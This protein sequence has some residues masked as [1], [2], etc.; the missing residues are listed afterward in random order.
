M[1]HKN[2]LTTWLE[3]YGHW[4][5][6]GEFLQYGGQS[7]EVSGEFWS[8][9]ELGNIE[10]RAASSCAH[11]YG[12]RKVSSESFTSG[13]TAFSGYPL[14]MKRRGDRFFTEGINNTLL[15]VYIQQPYDDKYPGVNAPFG[16]EFNRKNTWFSYLDLFISYLKRCDYLL[17]Q[18]TYVADV[19]YFIGEDTPKMTGVCDPAL[20]QGYSFDY[21][22][23]EVLLKANVK[24]GKIILPGGMSYR[25]LIL[26]KQETMRPELLKKI[27]KLIHAGAVVVGEPPK[28][29]PSLRHYPEAD[30]QVS[31]SARQ[32]W[33]KVDGKTLRFANVGKG[34]IINGMD[35]KEVFLLIGHRPDCLIEHNDSILFVHR[36]LKDKDIYFLSNQAETVQMIQPCFN[37]R[38]KSP[39]WW[40][41]VDGSVR[42]LPDYHPAKEGMTVPIK[43]EPLESTFIVFRKKASGRAMTVASSAGINYPGPDTLTD[44]SAGWTVQFDPAFDGPREPQKIYRLDWWTNSSNDSIRYYSG[45]AVYQKTVTLDR[46]PECDR[47]FLE[48]GRLSAMARVKVNGMEVGGVWTAPWHVD[49]KKAIRTGTNV[50]EVSVVNTWANRLIGDSRLPEES[51]KTWCL[52]NPYH[53][54]SPLQPSGLAG[55]VYLTTVNY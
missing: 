52:V 29:S 43:L 50:I 39:E 6:P 48:L 15:H 25:V 16:N 26:P 14:K 30:K 8:E 10:N 20:P 22:N 34:M 5:F 19:A 31:E 7:D 51:R 12:K 9:G 49:I 35:M 1:A 3:N 37:T 41:P 4:G 27:S 38:N 46:I 13:G 40:N 32:L 45:T 17:Q 47:L 36:R 23:S 18:G 53:T 55:P 28:R 54:G 24:D 11:I 2:G 21:I 44:L 42:L 33:G